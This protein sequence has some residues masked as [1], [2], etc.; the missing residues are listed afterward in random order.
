MFKK[1]LES[2]SVDIEKFV[3]ENDQEIVVGAL[4][5]PLIAIF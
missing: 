2:G 3:S 4:G 5:S 1:E